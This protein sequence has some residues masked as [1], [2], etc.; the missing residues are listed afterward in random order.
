MSFPVVN[1]HSEDWDDERERPGYSWHRLQVG[2]RLGAELLGASLYEL[3]PGERSF[4]HHFHYGNEELLLAVA[5]APTVRHVGGERELEPGDVI[6]FRRGPEGAHQVVNRSGE[7][8]KFLMVSTMNRPEV[9][10]YPDSGKVGVFDEAPGPARDAAR[11][12]R[13]YLPLAA[14]VDYF[15]GE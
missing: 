3:Q 5:G 13:A 12:L 14:E 8:C 2:K 11:E 7:P 9:A 1:L 6:V 15:D 4:P 10:V